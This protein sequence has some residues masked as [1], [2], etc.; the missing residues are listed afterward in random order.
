MASSCQNYPGGKRA[1]RLMGRACLAVGDFM[2]SS[3]ESLRLHAGA[4][5]AEAGHLQRPNSVSTSEGC[6]PC[7]QP[8]RFLKMHVGQTL[9]LTP[10]R[11]DYMQSALRA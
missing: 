11:V 4:S 2:R 5:R 6:R 8:L 3:V 7:S 1:L 9:D 10:D